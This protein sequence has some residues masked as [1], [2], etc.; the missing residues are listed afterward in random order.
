MRI[1]PPVSAVECFGRVVSA[2]GNGR[3]IALH[4]RP[5]LSLLIRHSNLIR[6]IFYWSQVAPAIIRFERTHL[7][8]VDHEESVDDVTHPAPPNF[9]DDAVVRNILAITARVNLTWVKRRTGK[10]TAFVHQNWKDA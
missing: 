1:D 3:P 10:F 2:E 7:S 9:P 8:V 4:Y 6:K 5:V